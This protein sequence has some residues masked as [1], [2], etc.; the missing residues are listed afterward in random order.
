MV[1][2]GKNLEQELDSLR[3]HKSHRRSSKG[4][5]R[6]TSPWILAGVVL[7]VAVS[8]AVTAARFAWQEIEVEVFRV[9]AGGEPGS[10]GPP[11]VLNASGYIVAHRKIQLTAKVVGKVAW[12]GVEKG[13]LVQEGQVLVRLEDAEYRA[14]AQQAEGQLASL[15]AQLSEL[16]AGSRPEEIAR[17]NANLARA[18]ADLKNARINLDRVRKLFE[19]EV[20]PRQDLDNAQSRFEAEAARVE[21]LAKEADLVR[22]GPREEQIESMRGRVKQARGQLA[23]RRTFLD[24]TVIRAP[25]TGTILEKAVEQG[26]FVTTSFVGDRGAKG[27]VVTLADLND[28]QVELDISQ[29][30]FSR[31]SMDQ[32]ATL[33]TDAFP[34]RSYRGYIAEIAPEANRQKA[35]V[36]VKVQVADPDSFLRPEM[37]AQVAFLA[38]EEPSN[39]DRT[40]SGSRITVP[41]ASIRDRQGRK[42]VLVVLQGRAS[43]RPVRIG[44]PTAEGV[45]VT[46]GLIGGEDIVVNPPANLEDGHRV[47]RAGN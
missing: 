16:E 13:D 44:D 24:S 6:W 34:D 37:N 25:I 41:T 9:V 20:L 35:T 23:L 14:Q 27:Y 21:S 7:L 47:R 42:S 40:P 30:D 2:S 28:L 43:E 46:E 15:L 22:L 3:I 33:S 26:E 36:Q 19:E 8:A 32:K 11:V 17:A 39:G 1:E 10:Q 29:D 18:Q 31:L 5:S 12:I 45:I 4:P 38:P